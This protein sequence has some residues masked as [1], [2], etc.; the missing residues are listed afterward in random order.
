MNRQTRRQQKRKLDKYDKRTHFPKEEVEALNQ[1]AYDLGIQHAIKAASIALGLG[2]S[3]QER[4][5]EKLKFV[6]DLEDY[7]VRKTE[8][9]A[10]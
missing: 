5:R 9:K 8:G 10:L 7:V 2:E 6:Q 3:R 1:M 4:I